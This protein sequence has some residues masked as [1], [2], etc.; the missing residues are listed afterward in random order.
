MT[1]TP[2]R[3]PAPGVRAAAPDEAADDE[4]QEATC[5]ITTTTTA[6]STTEE[7]ERVARVAAVAIGLDAARSRSPSSPCSTS[8]RCTATRSSPN[9]RSRSDGRWRP[10]PGSIYPTLDRLEDRGAVSSTDVDG[11]RQFGL[12]D[13]GRQI[14]AE[15]RDAQGDDADEP[16]NQSGT[17]GRGDMRRLMSELGGQVRQIARFGSAE[18][19]N[20]ATTV[21]DDTKRQLY[22]ILA[23]PRPTPASNRLRDRT[24]D[25]VRPN[26]SANVEGG[27]LRRLGRPI[28]KTV[29]HS[30]S[31]AWSAAATA[32]AVGTRPISPTP[33]MP[34]GDRG[35]GTSTR[36]TSI[37]GTSF[38]RRM[39]SDR[40]VMFVGKPGLGVGREVLGQ[41]VAEP[42]V[43]DALD[44]A[45]DEHRVDGLADVVDGDDLLD[46]ARLGSAIAIWAA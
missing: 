4:D 17:G 31:T 14:L 30:P 44:L 22:E 45:F 41:R 37:S 36:C 46:V 39:P 7:V 32:G 24:G 5:T 28:G 3:P 42:H 33:L 2:L 38:A 11:K 25:P 35:W 12:T 16:W 21:L 40:S 26:P 1:L 6:P 8:D 27:Q 34:Y 13:R 18:Q 15:L 23:R 20:A 10:S 43:H 29:R 9:S 19:R